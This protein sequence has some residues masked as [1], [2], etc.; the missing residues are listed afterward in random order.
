M[1]RRI[2]VWRLAGAWVGAVALAPAALAQESSRVPRIG[3]LRWGAAGDEAQVALVKALAAIGY[4][5]NDE[6]RA[7]AQFVAKANEVIQ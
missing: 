2:A 6:D 7:T 1:K 3:V 4:R 5:E